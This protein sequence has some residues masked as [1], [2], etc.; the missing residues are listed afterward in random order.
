ML[1]FCQDHMQPHDGCRPDDAS[2]SFP[3]TRSRDSRLEVIWL[4]GMSSK[5]VRVAH[6]ALPVSVP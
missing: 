6:A 1:L 3:H 5:T 2:L 4:L